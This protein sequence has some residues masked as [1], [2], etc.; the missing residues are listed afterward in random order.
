MSA[1]DLFTPKPQQLRQLPNLESVLEFWFP[2]TAYQSFWFDGSVDS[3]IRENYSQLLA[4]EEAGS[5][6]HLTDRRQLLA[7]IILLDQ[8]T[9]NIY[10]GSEAAYKNDSK[11]LQLALNIIVK[12]EE[13]EYPLNERIFIL[14]PLRHSKKSSYLDIVRSLNDMYIPVTAEETQLLNKFRKATLA[15]Y[16]A[17]EDTIDTYMPL[18]Q[19][20]QQQQQQ[21]HLIAPIPLTRSHS[22]IYKGDYT[23]ILD[24][25]CLEWKNYSTGT[26]SERTESPLF[27]A[28]KDFFSK[29]AHNTIAISLSGGVDSMV[30]LDVCHALH[31]TGHLKQ[32]WAI[33]MEYINREDDAPLETRFLKEY[34]DSL[35][36]PIVVRKIYYMRRDEVDR[37][38]YEEETRKARF[39]TYRYMMRQHGIQTFCLGHHY[40]DLG[41]NVL[42]NIFKGRDIL[43]LFVMD[44]TATQDSVHLSRPLLEHPKSDIYEY[45][46]KYHIPY[47]KDTTPD[48]SCRGTIR[49]R[50]MPLLEDQWGGG[51]HK[52]LADTGKR[53]REWDSVIE[54]MVIRPFF[55]TVKRTTNSISFEVTEQLLEQPH[56]LW[57]R[58][59]LELFHSMG[60]K[61]ISN[62]NLTAMLEMLKKRYNSK[63][64]L[65]ITFSNGFKGEFKKNVLTI[66][67]KNVC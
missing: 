15:S 55:N 19:Q 54:T 5:F 18:S 29:T 64:P 42:M 47:F 50:I 35:H 61:M 24:N 49:R 37:E 11:A 23:T 52:T 39:A 17:L 20:Q 36:I 58:I 13:V 3:K 4:L 56:V 41:E 62:K 53:S 9:R 67:S 22:F 7:R 44:E 30:M 21:Q 26:A 31:L 1:P 12:H 16:S 65:K 60:V 43:D 2:T 8:F 14:M 66:S 48:W 10:R 59:L 40:G 25:V 32:V 28:L 46:H 51:I 63:E 45:S 34:C 33:H 57:H 6:D 38:F 27:N